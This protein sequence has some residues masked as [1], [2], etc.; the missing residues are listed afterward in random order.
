MAVPL[1]EIPD[2]HVN[3]GGEDILEGDGLTV[4]AGEVHT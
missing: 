4:G 1:F 3:T 2:L